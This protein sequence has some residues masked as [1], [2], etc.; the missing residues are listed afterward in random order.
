MFEFNSNDPWGDPDCSS[1]LN[2][3]LLDDPNIN[4]KK[5]TSH[6]NKKK[7]PLTCFLCVFED[8]I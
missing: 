5:V 8:H 1:Y 6:R 4:G 3:D 2:K 7:L